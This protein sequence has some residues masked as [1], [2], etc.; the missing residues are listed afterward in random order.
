MTSSKLVSKNNIILFFFSIL[1]ISFISGNAVLELNIFFI[2]IFFLRELFFD[3]DYFG[4]ILKNKFFY[5][6]VSLWFYLI[7]NALFGLNYEDSLRRSI[8]FFRYIFLIFAL[9]Y[10]LRNK[11]I[12][13]KVINIYTLILLF[14]SFDIFFEF[15]FGKNILGF[16]SPMKNERIVSFFKD[17]LIVGSFLASFLFIIF[18]KFF[19]EDKKILSAILFTIFSV[20]ILIT[21]E[22][23]ISI[24][25]LISIFLIIFFVL[26]SPKLKIYTAL[27]TILLISLI[28]TNNNL[29]MR[30]KNFLTHFE[31]NF[32]KED[33]YG[34]I[35]ETKYLNQSLF[36]YELLKNNY[37]L[38]VGTKNYSSA[39]RN[40]KNTSKKTVIQKNAIHCYTHPHQF[41]Y[42]FVSEHGIIGSII[43]L[44][45]LISLFLNKSYIFTKNDKRKLFIFKIYFIISM[46]PIFPTGSFFSSLQLFQF[47]L[48][49]AI[50]LVYYETKRSNYKKGELK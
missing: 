36:S 9:V 11:Q 31:K 41:Y 49:Y 6:L 20:S 44:T 25:I 16:E 23:S 27:F 14:I 28:F 2:I 45:I 10:F 8:F 19:N 38:G 29:N 21:G 50:Y 24:K 26:E 32:K 13:D 22:R 17:E 33:I 1:P 39:C 40:L 46:V 3:K 5:L 30:Y 48:N 42:E 43:I 7:I 37:L 4:K 35:L 18:G 15:I 34:S 47:F 12:R